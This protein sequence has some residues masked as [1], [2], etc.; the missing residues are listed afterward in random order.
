MARSARLRTTLRVAGR[1][2][3]PDRRPQALP[4]CYSRF[5]AGVTNVSLAS[6]GATV[7]TA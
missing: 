5:A 7:S 4:A 3:W 1:T 2:M 6:A